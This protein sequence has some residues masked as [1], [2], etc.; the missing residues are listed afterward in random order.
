MLLPG[1]RSASIRCDKG[2]I[3][4]HIGASVADGATHIFNRGLVSADPAMAA[5]QQGR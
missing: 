3:N 4:S 5:I 2:M 1:T